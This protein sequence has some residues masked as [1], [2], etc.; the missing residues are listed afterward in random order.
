[1]GNGIA[2]ASGEKR[3]VQHRVLPRKVEQAEIAN[4]F[5]SSEQR[6]EM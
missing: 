3:F 6:V 1:M 5:G 2:K 4:V